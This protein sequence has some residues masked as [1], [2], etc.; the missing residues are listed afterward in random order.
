MNNE[1]KGKTVLITGGSSGIG[2]ATARQFVERGS[3]L[4]LFAR[5]MEAL[6]EAKESLKPKLLNENQHIE[7]RSVDVSNPNQVNQ[8]IGEIIQ[9]TGVPD[10]LIN[11]AG[12]TYPGYLEKLEP[13]T[14]RELMDINYM[15]VVNM[16]KA[17]LPYM[18]ERGSGSIVNVSS[19]AAIISLPGYTAYGA[20]KFAVRGFSESLRSEVKRKGIYVGVIFPPDTD[21]PQLEN[22]LPLRP[23]EVT[24]IASLDTVIS[25]DEVAEEI[26]KGIE[27]RKF[28]MIPGLG[29]K[30]FYWLNSITG[31]LAYPIID[32]LV[33]WAIRKVNNNG[34]KPNQFTN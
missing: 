34:S 6:E 23:P 26:I 13:N 2:L 22:E 5:R 7:I 8:I 30:F 33:N 19:F 1:F 20:S 12:I 15:G 25:P 32:L 4:F 27:K 31:T 9:Q 21:T 29:N 16:T 17:V 24:I 28:I 3:H 11:S 18:L 14:I 10:I